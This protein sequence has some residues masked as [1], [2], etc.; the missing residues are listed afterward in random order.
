[1]NLKYLNNSDLDQRMKSLAQKERDLLHEVLLTIKEIDSR[2]TYLELGFGSLFDYL[3]MG[4]GY[5]E[6]SA[7]RRIDAARLIRELPQ[8]AEKIQSG[9]LKLNQ[10]S[11]VQ[12]ASREIAKSKSLENDKFENGK[13]TSAQKLEVI[14]SLCNKSSA[15]SQHQVA[16]F[17]ELP[18]LQSTQRK[19]QADESVRIE[20][21]LSKEAFAKVKRAQELLS[22]AVANQDMGQFLEF[23]AEKVIQQ[24]TAVPKS[25]IKD[26]L[27][28]NAESE[29]DTKTCVEDV[30][31]TATMAVQEAQ[32]D[33]T[34]STRKAPSQKD[35]KTLRRQQ[36]CCQ[37]INP[38]TGRRCQSTWKLQVDHKKSRWAGGTH[39]LENLQQLCAAHNKMKYRKEIGLKYT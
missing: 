3:V 35:I 14:E 8:V 18:V 15:E 32:L 24:K 10:I 13:V 39:S 21:T 9:E 22:H 25:K 30:S 6:G 34:E 16:A 11:L 28:N 27:A 33:S 7:Q 38:L 2:R 1:M 19:I 31:N 17:F 20:L 23:L 5:S 26:H 12:K 36:D 37:F 4:V 29:V